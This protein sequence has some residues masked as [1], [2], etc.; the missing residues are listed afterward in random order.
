MAQM[1]LEVLFSKL[2]RRLDNPTTLKLATG[3]N[4]TL[5]RLISLRSLASSIMEQGFT[6]PSWATP[7]S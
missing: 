4:R 3:S 7:G 6:F 1:V 5:G 2:A